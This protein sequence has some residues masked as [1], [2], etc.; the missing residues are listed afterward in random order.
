MRSV[1]FVFLVFMVAG[2]YSGFTGFVSGARGWSLVEGMGL[3]ALYIGIPVAIPM[4]VF[5]VIYRHRHIG[6]GML[7]VLSGCSVCLLWLAVGFTGSMLK[8]TV[9]ASVLLLVLF[10]IA[11]LSGFVAQRWVSAERNC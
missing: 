8:V 1:L 10:L 4:V 3:S 7:W 9:V 6:L 2:S 11:A 5:D